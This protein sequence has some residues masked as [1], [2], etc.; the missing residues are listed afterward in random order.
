LTHYEM[1]KGEQGIEDRDEVDAILGEAK[2]VTVA[3]CS[4]GEPY[5]VA[6]SHGYDAERVAIY[7][8][9]A[10]EGRK[11]DILRE[12][13]VVW[14]QAVRDLGVDEAECDHHWATVMFRGEVSFPGD[15]EEKRHA[16]SV[17]VGQF[18][19]DAEAFLAKEDADEKILGVNIGRID[20][21]FVSG[22]RSA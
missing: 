3:M 5:L 1:R 6:L 15:L 19:G 18:G 20:I 4:G 22:K 2:Y 21:G 8:H 7:F 11:I 9:C 12:N 16:I 17:L 10:H 14:G 13:P